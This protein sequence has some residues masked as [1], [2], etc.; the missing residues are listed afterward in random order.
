MSSRR[1]AAPLFA[2]VTISFV[3]A[4]VHSTATF[5]QDRSVFHFVEKFGPH[6]VGL[7]IVD[8]Y[9]Y[10]RTYRRTTDDLGKPYQGERARPLQ[11]LIWYPGEHS[12]T[13]PLTVGDYMNLWET[14]TSF[15]HPRMSAKAKEWLAGVTPAA[16]ATPLRAVRDATLAPGRFPVVIYAPGA[17]SQSWENL[18]LCEYLASYGYVVVASPD[19]GAT[20]RDMTIDLAGINTQASD[21]S[22]LVGYA[23][24]LPDADMSAIAVAGHS[25][26]G[27]S[28]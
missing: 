21:I 6:A 12:G 16:L 10:S 27:I 11:T 4:S 25:W 17:S 8:Q 23:R 24:T 19:M 7:K 3:L 15:D 20:T 18:D 26:G 22:Y 9:D 13:K 14:E 5:A 2:C 28:N 1:C